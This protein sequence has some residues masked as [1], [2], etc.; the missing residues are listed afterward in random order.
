MLDILNECSKE[1]ELEVEPKGYCL[2]TFSVSFHQILEGR[3]LLYSS[4]RIHLP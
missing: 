4:N 2:G 3:D 1:E